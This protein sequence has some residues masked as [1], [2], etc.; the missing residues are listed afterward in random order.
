[1]SHAAFTVTEYPESDGKPM[2]ET[3]LHRKAMIRQIGILERYYAGQQS[4]VSGDLL[5]YYV[6]GNP[7]KFVVPD[8][9]PHSQLVQRI[10]MEENNNEINHTM[11]GTLLDWVG[12]TLPTHAVAPDRSQ[13][14][15]PAD[16]Q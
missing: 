13:L 5:L 1:M 7:E 14:S 9:F 8:V 12:S 6:Q 2:G 15:L 11:A 16:V 4:Y 10:V 3:D